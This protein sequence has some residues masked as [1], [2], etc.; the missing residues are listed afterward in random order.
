MI[1][2][3][4]NMVNRRT[5]IIVTDILARL[6]LD[7]A[8]I[9]GGQVVL[10]GRVLQ[11]QLHMLHNTLQ[12][13]GLEISIDKKD[14]LVQ[15]IKNLIYEMVNCDEQPLPIKFSGYLSQRLH[16]SYTYLSAIFSH[17][18]HMSIE[19][20]LIEQRIQKVKILITAHWVLSN[21]A[22]KMN[23]SSATHLYAQFKKVTGITASEYKFLQEREVMRLRA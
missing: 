16:Y 12:E 8:Y 11:Y 9:A 3:I 22:C 1:I 13:Q 17:E 14:L 6:R 10:R 5:E 19:R 4:K 15:K 18:C 7:V 23:Y 21:I 2:N 20:Y